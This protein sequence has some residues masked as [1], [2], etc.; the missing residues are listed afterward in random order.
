M[1]V[2]IHT[3]EPPGG[4]AH[5]ITLC[6]AQQGQR[7]VCPDLGV[8]GMSSYIQL[9]WRRPG[10]AAPVLTHSRP[11]V[12]CGQCPQSPLPM[13]SDPCSP[14]HALLDGLY[15][16]WQVAGFAFCLGCKAM[17]MESWH[18]AGSSVGVGEW[19][20]GGQAESRKCC[21]LA[22]G[23]ASPCPPHIPSERLFPR[24]YF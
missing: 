13:A 11:R 20:A 23:S 10:T 24:F 19:W 14:L 1:P 12:L 2:D 6:W 9:V 8:E 16:P 3:S 7:S 15:S 18:S 17:A 22:S 4:P 5:C 21:G